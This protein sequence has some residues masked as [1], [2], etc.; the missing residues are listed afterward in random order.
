MPPYI[1]FQGGIFFAQS[2]LIRKYEMDI[3]SIDH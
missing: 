2:Q 1:L 3:E